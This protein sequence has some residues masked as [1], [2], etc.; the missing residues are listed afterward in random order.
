MRPEEPAAELPVSLPPFDVASEAQHLAEPLV[1]HTH[2]IH[3]DWED[4]DMNGHVNNVNAIGW[5]LSL[6]DYDFLMKWRPQVVEVNF[7]A[8]MFCGQKFVVMREDRPAADGRM[9]FDYLV[10]R[11]PD[12]I[13][14]VRVR[15]AYREAQKSG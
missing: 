7:L 4:I 10:L 14:T 9:L 1:R 12:Q 6:H 8:E 15:I 3:A 11:E 13:A 2:G 5:C